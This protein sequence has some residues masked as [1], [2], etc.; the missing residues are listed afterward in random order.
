[1]SFSTNCQT[2]SEFS[3]KN[4]LHQS[5][6]VEKESTVK[7]NHAGRNL[8]LKIFAIVICAVAF[9]I[10]IAGFFIGTGIL[11]AGVAS[12]VGAPTIIPAIA[13]MVFCGVAAVGS[14]ILFVYCITKL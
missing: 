14:G 11:I 10:F 4:G 3:K 5:S 9:T 12:G 8:I 2:N 7:G 1:M 13:A 6:I